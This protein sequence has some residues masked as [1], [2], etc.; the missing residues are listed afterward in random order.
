MSSW[1]TSPSSKRWPRL[2]GIRPWWCKAEGRSVDST[3]SLAWDPSS[4]TIH[5]LKTWCEKSPNSRQAIQIQF[6]GDGNAVCRTFKALHSRQAISN[7]PFHKSPFSR[8]HAPAMHDRSWPGRFVCGWSG[9][10][11]VGL[12][13]VLDVQVR[14]RA[15]E[16]HALVMV[17][18][19]SV[20]LRTSHVDPL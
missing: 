11:Q 7:K 4:G 1:R 20:H 12:E 14:P 19:R 17:V 15:H 8:R 5:R 16:V 2:S 9:V 13:L 3:H 18:G 6:R 10:L